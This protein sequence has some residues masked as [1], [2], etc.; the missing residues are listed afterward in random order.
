GPD[1]GEAPGQLVERPR[2]LGPEHAAAELQPE[3][4][5]GD[6]P[7]CDYDLLRLDFL[8]VLLC[9]DADIPLFGERAV[10]VDE[11][12]LVLLEQTVDPAGQGLDHLVAV[13]A[14]AG[15][16]DRHA[17]GLDPERAPALDLG[18][19]VRGAQ[20]GLRG[21]A[22]VVE[23]AAPDAVLLDDRRL[24]PELRGAD[25]GDVATGPRADD[26]AAEAPVRH[27]GVRLLSHC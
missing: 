21:D 7:H 19:H 2:G 22:R 24:H 25:G 15:E 18:H 14:D 27:R 12:D 10:T 1:D 16:V 11:L 4:R 3:D 9:A 17:L 13:L 5:L 26:H 8:A 6:G 20:D 23:A